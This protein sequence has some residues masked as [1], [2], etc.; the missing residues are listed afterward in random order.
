MHS[1]KETYESGRNTPVSPSIPNIHIEMQPVP[2][3]GKVVL[4][5][6]ESNA[7]NEQTNNAKKPEENENRYV[8]E[9]SLLLTSELGYIIA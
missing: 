5:R 6:T 9:V 1:R 2:V 8:N 3:N 4:I 7:S